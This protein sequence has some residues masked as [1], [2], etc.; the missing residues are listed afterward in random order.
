V[1]LAFAFT[2]ADWL[3]PPGTTILSNRSKGDQT[4]SLRDL[5]G[6]FNFR[7]KLRKS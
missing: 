1:A 5:D 6:A 4:V 7:L 2:D 3:R